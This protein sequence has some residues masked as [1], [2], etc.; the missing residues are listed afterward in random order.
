VIGAE[1]LIRWNH[2]KL[3]LM[4]SDEFIPL[5]EETGLIVPIGDWVINRA[6]K[7]VRQWKDK[8]VDMPVSINLSSKQFYGNSLVQTIAQ[9]LNRYSLRP[10]DLE[11]EIT[12]SVAMQNTTRTNAQLKEL[13]D[14]GVSITMDDFG[15][16][17]SSLS[18]LRGLYIHKLKI[19]KSFVKDMVNNQ[20]DATIIRTIISMSHTLGLKV[21]AEG[22][23]ELDQMMLLSSMGCDIGQGYLMCKPINGT[24][25]PAFLVQEKPVTTFN[26]MQALT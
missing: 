8:G 24:E 5:A 7:Q 11:L 23:E 20:Y 3:G 14:M 25:M 6:C 10:R 17:Y 12:E 4:P 22:I 19:D 9:A 16:G 1:A 2:P 21:C 13:V 15:T 18:Y 26:P